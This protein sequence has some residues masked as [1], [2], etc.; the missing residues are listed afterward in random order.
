MI[1]KAKVGANFGGLQNYLLSG[2]RGTEL[3]AERVAEVDTRNLPLDD[4]DQAAKVMHATAAQNPYVRVPVYHLTIN[5]PPESGLTHG[6]LMATG[7]RALEELSLGEH[8]A[9]L[10]IH[11]DATTDGRSRP[12]LHIMV[13]SVHPETLRVY[14]RRLDWRRIDAVLDRIGLELG[15]PPVPRREAPE[16]T[17]GYDFSDNVPREL[18]LA[19]RRRGVAPLSVRS[20]EVVRPILMTASSWNEVDRRLAVHGL[21]LEARGRGLV[22]ANGRETAKASSFGREVS[23]P[24]LE[25]RLGESFAAH[26]ESRPALPE[27][28]AFRNRLE[29]AFT[30]SESPSG[31][32]RQLADDG[33]LAQFLPEV[34]ALRGLDQDAER[35]AETDALE[36]TFAAVERSPPEL[37]WKALLRDVGKGPAAVLDRSGE[38]YRFLGHEIA[39]AELVPEIAERLYLPDGLARSIEDAVRSPR[40]PSRLAGQAE[41]ESPPASEPPA[42]VS[43][44]RSEGDEVQHDREPVVPV[45]GA[46]TPGSPGED[47]APL[48]PLDVALTKA[49]LVS[50][51]SDARTLIQEGAV[52]IAGETVREPDRLLPPGEHSVTVRL[53]SGPQAGTLTV[54]DP[55]AVVR[56]L[57]RSLEDRAGAVIE[58]LG[59]RYAVF[60]E[61]VLRAQTR[62]DQDPKALLEAV[63]RSPGL[64]EVPS[65]NQQRLFTTEL[66]L[67]R[68][69][70]LVALGRALADDIGAV[71]AANPDVS[72]EGARELERP[73]FETAVQKSL[74]GPRLAAFELQGDE[75]R[76]R[77]YDHLSAGA[78]R[79]G[80]VVVPV[81]SAAGRVRQLE[82]RFGRAIALPRGAG[83]DATRLPL[84][85]STVLLVDECERIGQGPAAELLDQAWRSGARVVLLG[86]PTQER[87]ITAGD[88]FATL[89]EV[90]RP[91]RLGPAHERGESWQQEALTVLRTGRAAD[92]LAAYSQAGDLYVG[93][94][95]QEAVQAVVHDWQ[96]DRLAGPERVQTAVAFSQKRRAML[97]AAIH[98]LRVR[99]GELGRAVDIDGKSVAIGEWVVFTRGDRPGLLVET[100]ESYTP[101]RG[102]VQGAVGT[103]VEASSDRVAVVLQDGRT[104][105]F[106]PAR[107]THLDHA[108]ALPPASVGGVAPDRVYVL[109]DPYAEGAE[110]LAALGAAGGDA[111]I[112]L[113]RG[114]V[115]QLE[116]LAQGWNATTLGDS[117]QRHAPELARERADQVVVPD[118][119]SARVAWEARAREDR[120]AAG[121]LLQ[122]VE[123]ER[124][125]WTRDDLTRLA[126]RS[127]AGPEAVAWALRDPAVL[128]LRT[129][130]AG[131]TWYTT[132]RTLEREQSTFAHARAMAE[133]AGGP[134][135]GRAAIDQALEA[136]RDQLSAEQQEAFR[137][138]TRDPRLTLATGY[139]GTGKTRLFVT[140][141]EVYG[142]HGYTVVGMAPT[143]AAAERLR[144]EAGIPART[145]D[146]YLASWSR[147][148][149]TLS[150]ETVV[151]LDEAGMVDTERMEALLRHADEAG[152][153]VI[154]VGDTAQ[155]PPVGAGE[156]FRG[157]VT[158]HGA[159]VLEDIR[160]QQTSWEQEA[161]LALASGRG[162]EAIV[163]YEEHGRIRWHGTREESLQH[164][165]AEVDRSMRTEPE[166][167]HVALA[168]RN[169]DVQEL[170]ERIRALRASRGE[171]GESFE[172]DVVRRGGEREVGRAPRTEPLQ[173]SV[174]D[175]VVFTR[176]DHHERTVHTVNAG[177]D[178]SRG[179]R[180]GTF[181]V[182]AG[183][184]PTAVEVELPTGRRVEFEP[185][186]WQ[187]LDHAYA[188]TIHRAQGL[189]AD[190][191]AVVPDQAMSQELAYT[192]LTRHRQSLAVYADRET[193]ADAT[194]LS[195]AISRKAPPDLARD[196]LAIRD[197][198][199]A[200]RRLAS[201][202]RT[203]ES[204][205]TAEAELRRAQTVGETF[206]R[207]VQEQ[208]GAFRDLHHELGQVYRDSRAALAA[209][210]S[211]ASRDGLAA[212]E[213]ALAKPEALGTLREGLGAQKARRHT[214]AAA[215]ALRRFHHHHS[216]AMSLD[217]PRA[218][219]GKKAI[220]ASGR[221]V[222]GALRVIQEQVDSAQRQ[223]AHRRR[224]EAADLSPTTASTS[225]SPSGRTP[226]RSARL[227]HSLAHAA[228][229]SR[230]L[231]D[232]ADLAQATARGL[233]LFWEAR[234]LFAER[235]GS[236]QPRRQPSAER[237]HD[238]GADPPSR[239]GSR[240]SERAS[241]SR[242]APGRGPRTGDVERPPEPAA[243]QAAGLRSLG[244]TQAL[245]ARIGRLREVSRALES[246]ERAR[247]AMG[248]ALRT[249]GLS[250]A[251]LAGAKGHAVAV[252]YTVAQEISRRVQRGLDL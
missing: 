43:Q 18:A 101:R 157:L 4:P 229:T 118:P 122:K 184:S 240:G 201:R 55:F 149:D 227:L 59:R 158:E 125:A 160:R 13:N 210:T 238:R 208:S 164:L 180:N 241:R 132:E 218:V 97:N 76:R 99:A 34:L 126:R 137:W 156:P 45:Y 219:P 61:T 28:L 64:I 221:D 224:R 71:R 226:M 124:A 123:T 35:Y 197:I 17:P 48:T 194:D 89:A 232:P 86:A 143:G 1:G 63:R 228:T 52:E 136:R 247:E 121:A 33:S 78:D 38:F 153:K 75:A 15:L 29:A 21:W 249:V 176:N 91:V 128:A 205:R 102:V 105:A 178:P 185:G 190:R 44:H 87:P 202:D 82:E 146:S 98:E 14:D 239:G 243:R 85:T 195:A 145:I 83:A 20:R 54:A 220:E 148:A 73:P 242:R 96:A 67:A 94:D 95:L 225:D 138:L 7:H 103:V 22:V 161:S 5:P 31:V 3:K 171:L 25:A 172:I 155:L 117:I 56:D 36:H 9:L 200:M 93:G 27:A 41:P 183:V 235:R 193:F 196:H 84:D 10:A 32:L 206:R 120:A 6:Q 16:R 251:H 246:P 74:T 182:V 50:D 250:A 245:A 106:D 39:G 199:R 139:A 115:P 233:Y 248:S 167:S 70:R 150:P 141:G 37:R 57:D 80:L 81:A 174:G 223:S 79:T 154:A 104:V 110:V 131:R 58:R 213:K 42:D 51:R 62:W 49:G 2:Q 8:Q 90:S 234:A 162:P 68:E 187:H 114:E 179:V 207:S 26:R 119:E 168:Y 65:A 152:A 53:S 23:G 30:G 92:A 127:G 188:L 88:A 107:W 189:T 211:T 214:A 47:L 134:Q 209:I 72:A 140:L 204:L 230:S 216:V 252:A 159:P 244:R 166:R 24:R 217:L 100:V 144:D 12:H 175:Y 237:S 151:V 135:L 222:A 181:G 170:N 60:S 116:T 130:A 112:Y 66:A 186:A 108:Y 169:R 46:L 147:A 109:A 231:D 19:A 215:E 212:V 133:S 77:L 165:A 142:E 113:S 236:Q 192:A 129:D 198:E 40:A 11:H 173:V 191:V 111:G 163:A 177:D 203:S 69:A